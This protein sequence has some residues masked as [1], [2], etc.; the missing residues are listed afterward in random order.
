MLLRQSIASGWLDYRTAW[1]DPRFEGLRNSTEF[2]QVLEDL[3]LHVAEMRAEAERL[4]AKKI[5][6]ADYPV[7]PFGK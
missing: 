1:L 7:E 3:R 6:I 5:N 2:G 4:C